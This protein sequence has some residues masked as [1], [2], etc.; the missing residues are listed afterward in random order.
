MCTPAHLFCTINSKLEMFMTLV[1]SL[2]SGAIANY[3]HLYANQNRLVPVLHAATTTRAKAAAWLQSFSL[4]Y[5]SMVQTPNASRGM[6]QRFLRNAKPALF[7]LPQSPAKT[8]QSL[9]AAQ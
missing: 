6:G 3:L 1:V 4:G 5:H 7:P 8:T 2:L 9:L